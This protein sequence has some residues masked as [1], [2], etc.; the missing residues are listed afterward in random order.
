MTTLMTNV[1]DAELLAMGA[2]PTENVQVLEITE[3]VTRD[4]SITRIVAKVQRDIIIA[5]GTARRSPTDKPNDHIGA[6]L[7]TARAYQ[8]LSKRIERRARGLVEHVADIAVQ[9]PIQRKKSEQWKT[10]LME[11][12]SQDNRV[13]REVLRTLREKEGSWTPVQAAPASGHAARL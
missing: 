13:Q 12:A 8:A 5:T 7:A 9:R 2:E 1:S 10:S 4:A 11:L 6:M 3:L